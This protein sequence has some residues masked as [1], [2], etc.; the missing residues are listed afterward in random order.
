M[1]AKDR[2]AVARRKKNSLLVKFIFAAE[3]RELSLAEAHEFWSVLEDGLED[4]L[5]LV[6]RGL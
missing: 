5:G 3:A 4:H 6:C 1:E 2:Y